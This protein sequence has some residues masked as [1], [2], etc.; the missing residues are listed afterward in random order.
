MTLETSAD[1]GA[2]SFA[3]KA[4]LGR[5][6]FEP[7]H[8]SGRMLVWRSIPAVPLDLYLL[9]GCTPGLSGSNQFQRSGRVFQATW[10]SNDSITAMSCSRAA[11]NERANEGGQLR[12]NSKVEMGRPKPSSRVLRRLSCRSGRPVP[13]LSLGDSRR[14]GIS[15][16]HRGRRFLIPSGGGLLSGLGV[17]VTRR[18]KRPRRRDRERCIGMAECRAEVFV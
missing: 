7:P 3:G 12:S 2:H 10:K 11:L 14:G 15:V 9:S 1:L 4:H 13:R 8:S 5:P 17:S 18:R 6:A 16:V